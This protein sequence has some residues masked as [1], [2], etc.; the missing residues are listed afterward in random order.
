MDKTTVIIIAVVIV[1][2][3]GLV[4]RKL[5]RSEDAKNSPH[6]A[7]PRDSDTKLGNQ[8]VKSTREKD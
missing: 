1:V 6:L 7:E 8:G 5:I 3:I 2:V 4:F